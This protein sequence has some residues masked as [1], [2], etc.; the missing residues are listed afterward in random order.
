VV[1]GAAGV[2]FGVAAGDGSVAVGAAEG[3]V[4]DGGEAGEERCSASGVSGDGSESGLFGFPVGPGEAGLPAERARL[5]G[6]AGVLGA[7]FGGRLV[8]ARF[9]GWLPF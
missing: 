8:A 3:A 2:G 1:A 4:G 5:V 6:A 9:R 7:E